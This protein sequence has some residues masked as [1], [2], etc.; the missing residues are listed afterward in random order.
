MRGTD[1]SDSAPLSVT[2]EV[3]PRKPHPLGV[4][5]GRQSQCLGPEQMGRRLKIFDLILHA[6]LGE[7]AGPSCQGA[8]HTGAA[9]LLSP[10]WLLKSLSG[11]DFPGCDGDA[12]SKVLSTL[13]VFSS[14]ITETH[15][16]CKSCWMPSVPL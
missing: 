4:G 10:D 16:S 11:V 7:E 1:G 6:L 2:P 15:E 12:L 13:K 3:S 14:E 5:L 8:S 9:W